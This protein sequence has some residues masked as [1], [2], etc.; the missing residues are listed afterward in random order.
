MKNTAN[1]GW[2]LKEILLKVGQKNKRIKNKRE[3]YMEN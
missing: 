3:N 2:T 1:T